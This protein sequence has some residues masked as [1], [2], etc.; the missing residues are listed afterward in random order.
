MSQEPE[1]KEDEKRPRKFDSCAYPVDS[2]DYRGGGVSK[3]FRA[4]EAEE[5]PDGGH[6]NHYHH[7]Y[8]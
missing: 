8:D 1:E 7:D 3:H 2:K 5:D 4:K 6:W